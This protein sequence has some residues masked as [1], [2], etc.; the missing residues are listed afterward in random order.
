MN[1][2]RTAHETLRSSQGLIE[3]LS[4]V[5]EQELPRPV[6]GELAFWLSAAVQDVAG[7]PTFKRRLL[8]EA[9]DHLDDRPDL[10]AWAMVGLGITTRSGAPLSEHKQWWDRVIELLP[11]IDNSA[12]EALLLGKV[13][14]AKTSAGDPAWRELV[15][16]IEYSLADAPLRRY[17]VNACLSVGMT[18]CYTGHYSVA[19][20]MLTR[21][22]NGAMACENGPLALIARSELALI[23]CCRGKWDE[24]GARVEALL[25]ELAGVPLGRIDAEV[26][27]G[28]LAYAH[29]DLEAGRRQL[30]AVAQQLE[31]MGEYHLRAIAVGALVRNAV[32]SR[33]RGEVEDAVARAD[34]LLD[35]LRSKELWAPAVRILPSATQAL[36][37]NGRMPEARALV[38]SCAREWSRL[39]VPLAP[40]AVRHAH[41]FLNQATGRFGDAADHFLRAAALYDDLECLYEAAQVR[42]QAAVAQFEVGDAGASE[43]LRAALATYHRLGATW[44]AARC[45]RVGRE[46]GMRLP[47]THR[48]GRKGYG[49]KL[50]PREGQV[51]RLAAEGLTDKEI[52]A[53]LF[54][55]PVTV[56]KHLGRAM[57]KLGVHSRAGVAARLSRRSDD[58][59][60]GEAP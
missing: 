13:A 57:R 49:D 47:V 3:L 41:G 28:I 7:D 46:H 9:V 8:L 16:R 12:F 4:K 60:Q 11:K 19:E 54:L 52:G 53:K 20:R 37:A 43:T 29:G 24:L 30:V 25:D 35:E 27:A 5:L 17:E 39:D 14:M 31:E 34:R 48:G 22:L 10:Q 45:V 55:A 40:A 6:R 21:A 33:E 26:I 42:E 38:G 32:V 1:L 18:A 56:S 50:S 15:A 36:L 58:A 2:G 51:A 44:D 59:R 23:D